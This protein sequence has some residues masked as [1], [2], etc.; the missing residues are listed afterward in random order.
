MSGS[1]SGLAK[2][3]QDV[4]PRAVYTHCYSH[5]LN[6]AA[7][8][9]ISK[10]KFMESALET[11]HEI[12]NLIKYRL[13]VMQYFKN[14]KQNITS[15]QRV[16][17]SALSFFVQHDGLYVLSILDNYSVLLNT[18]EEAI[19]VARDYREQGKNTGGVITD[20]HL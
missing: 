5:S 17:A 3:V 4:G 2:R 12:T 16:T 14:Y 10:S 1:R 19:E 15:L 7:S 8:D 11:T 9:S 18:W 20:E 13:G 6:L